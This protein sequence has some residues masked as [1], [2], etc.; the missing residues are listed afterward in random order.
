M[1]FYNKDQVP[2]EKFVFKLSINQLYKSKVEQKELEF[3]LRAFLIKLTVSE[4]ITIPLPTGTDKIPVFM[5][6]HKIVKVNLISDMM[7]DAGGR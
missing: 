6:V 3:A 4:S 7:Q 2:V 5:G 1:I